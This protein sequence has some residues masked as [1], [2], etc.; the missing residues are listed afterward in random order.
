MPRL[1]MGNVPKRSSSV[2]RSSSLG[3]LVVET[4][5]EFGRIHQLHLSTS[6]EETARVISKSTANSHIFYSIGIFTSSRP[7]REYALSSTQVVVRLAA[8]DM[9]WA[10]R[11]EESPSVGICC[12]TRVIPKVRASIFL[13]PMYRQSL[14]KNW[15]FLGVIISCRV[16]PR[17]NHS[18]QP[19]N[20][21]YLR[22]KCRLTATHIHLS[23]PACSNRGSFDSHY[24]G[25]FHLSPPSPFLRALPSRHTS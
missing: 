19:L 17:E 25:G 2:E 7:N 11:L 24:A 12:G 5:D 6:P 23:W 3:M 8:H 16:H 10:T 4:A 13:S 9:I 15:I 20:F 14:L 18:G 22:C 1:V 21:R